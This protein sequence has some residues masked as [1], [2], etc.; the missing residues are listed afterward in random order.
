MALQLPS[1]LFKAEDSTEFEAYKPDK[2]QVQDSAVMYAD[3]LTQLTA[4]ADNFKVRSDGIKAT[5]KFYEMR[6]FMDEEYTRFKTTVHNPTPADIEGLYKSFE[7][8]RTKV[9]GENIS[10]LDWRVRTKYNQDLDREFNNFQTSVAQTAIQKQYT[11]TVEN[12]TAEIAMNADEL[13]KAFNGPQEQAA[14]D[15][16]MSSI[17]TLADTRDIEPG[18]K[19]YE[20]LVRE[21]TSKALLNAGLTALDEGRDAEV[22]SRLADLRPRMDDADWRH[23]LQAKRAK[24]LERSRSGRDKVIDMWSWVQ[25]DL[26]FKEE[27]GLIVWGEGTQFKTRKEAMD[28]HTH[29]SINNF[30]STQRQQNQQAQQTTALLETAKF[31]GTSIKNNPEF[32]NFCGGVVPSDGEQLAIKAAMFS[33]HQV[34]KELTEEQAGAELDYIKSIMTARE[35]S[36][37]IGRISG[38]AEIPNR[39]LT[40]KLTAEVKARPEM[41][42]GQS[43]DQITVNLRNKGIMQDKELHKLAEWVY[44]KNNEKALKTARVNTSNFVNS[45][46][47]KNALTRAFNDAMD[48]AYEKNPNRNSKIKDKSVRSN[49]VNQFRDHI[50]NKVVME[51]S[52]DPGGNVVASPALIR[53]R[54]DAKAKSLIG[55]S[56]VARDAELSKFADDFI[57]NSGIY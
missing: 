43:L 30:F 27:N 23:L 25:A 52:K 16:L 21:T 47:D 6:K 13:S 15:K 9:F 49:M 18:T 42:Q 33:K 24:D 57:A 3:T 37:Y 14:T 53:E 40:T 39:D 10:Q 51:I 50:V 28:W 38:T 22:E 55:G 20:R 11:A 48:R 26:K 1:V 17:Q 7:D 34:G 8:K 35:Y 31:I 36:A 32:V 2:V 54:L 41:Y 44:E 4:V 45:I 46:W 12:L 29:D 56:N 19:E 5:D